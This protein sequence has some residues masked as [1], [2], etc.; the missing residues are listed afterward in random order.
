MTEKEVFKPK[1]TDLKEG[2]NK[3]KKKIRK[4][5]QRTGYFLPP[6]L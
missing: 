5:R 4:N 3:C 1:I 6:E 2:K